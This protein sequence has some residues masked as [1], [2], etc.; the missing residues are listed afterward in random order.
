M[1]DARWGEKGEDPGC[2]MQDGGEKRED[3][4]CEIQD[5]GLKRGDDAGFSDWNLSGVFRRRLVAGWIF[6]DRSVLSFNALDEVR[7]LAAQFD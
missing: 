6:A 4:G 7:P 2:T 1:H 3:P 5:G